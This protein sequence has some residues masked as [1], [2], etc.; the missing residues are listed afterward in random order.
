M[1]VEYAEGEYKTID[2]ISSIV[3]ATGNGSS[4]A[5]TDVA[6]VKF[7]DSPASIVREDKEYMVTISGV[8]TEFATEKTEQ[9][10]MDEVILPNLTAGVSIGMNSIDSSMQ[11]EFSALFGAI[12][13][14]VF[15][16]FVVMA[17]QFES[18]RYSFMVMTTIPFSLIGSFSLLYL[19]D[20]DISMVTLVGFLMLVGTVVNN[21][22]LYVDTA[23]QYKMT[24]PL[25]TALIEAGATRIRPMLMT[26][27]TT[28]LS[29]LP[30]AFAIGNSGKMTQGLAVVN[31]GG[32][33][34]STIMC[35]LMLPGYYVIMS[36]KRGRIAM[37]TG[38][39]EGEEKN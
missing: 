24:M 15:L 2:Q 31:I 39:R 22:I 8:F 36:G 34:A 21:G 30:M 9:E 29:M 37:E 25:K 38:K 32:L 7:V 3:L 5:L 33:T 18:P 14:A 13:T 12:G 1:K 4:V 27:L 16:V 28:I 26:T 17:A 19:T 11:E 6:E 35:L 10:I 23:N 20:V